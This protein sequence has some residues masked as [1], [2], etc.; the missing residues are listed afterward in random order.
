MLTSR[1]APSPTG[2]LHL[3]HA[4]SA[5]LAHQAARAG[6]GRFLLRIEDLDQSRSRPEYV[7]AIA[8][9]LRWLGLEHDE[10]PLVQ[11]R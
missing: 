6:G 8:D 1:F 4:Y 9:D 3:G 2:Q 7:K 10:K 11:S 5:A